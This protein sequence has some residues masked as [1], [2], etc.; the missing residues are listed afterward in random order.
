MGYKGEEMFIIK[1]IGKS[2]FSPNVNHGAIKVY[3]KNA[4]KV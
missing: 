2:K 3:K 1:K 4:C